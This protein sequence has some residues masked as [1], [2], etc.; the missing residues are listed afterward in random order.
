MD[1]KGRD[2]FDVGAI[3]RRA[4]ISIVSAVDEHPFDLQLW[5]QGLNSQTL[6]TRGY[7]VMLVDATLQEDHQAAL[8]RFRAETEVRA[9]ISYHRIERGGRA[10]AL[11]R[12]L[13]SCI[14][15]GTI[16]SLV[17]ACGRRE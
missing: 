16:L 3:E 10:R 17:N 6:P 8:M 2:E 9:D 11:N 4:E 13:A 1:R 15:L 5:L 14:T 12:A 7:E